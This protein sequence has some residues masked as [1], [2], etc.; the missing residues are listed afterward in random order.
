MRFSQ[1]NDISCLLTSIYYIFLKGVERIL[2][3]KVFK[4]V[5]SVII[6]FCGIVILFPLMILIGLIIKIADKG[7]VLFKQERLGKNQE[8]FTIYKFRTM[9][10]NAYDIG[11]THTYEGDFRITPVGTFLRK[12]S[13]DE[14]PQLFNILRNDMTIIGPRPILPEEFGSFVDN[15]TYG[16]RF[17]VLPGMFCTVDC[18]YRATASRETQFEMDVDYIDNIS[19]KLDFNIFFKILI[20]V[21][22]RKNV[23]KQPGEH[24]LTTKDMSN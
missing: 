17:D 22:K 7:E 21:I 18:E 1:N 19:A 15:Y 6:A 3:R 24:I 20:A 5:L 4:R 16:R 9:V 11:G 2:Y 10:E 8:I 12:T 14:L 23:Y 13:L